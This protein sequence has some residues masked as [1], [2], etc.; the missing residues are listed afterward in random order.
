LS[1]P[2][3][4]RESR[5]RQRLRRLGL[6]ILVIMA[7]ASC[8]TGQQSGGEQGES[9]NPSPSPPKTTPSTKA[10]APQNLEVALGE[11]AELSDRTLTVNDFQGNFI[12]PGEFQPNPQ[13]GN[14]FFAVN[15]SVSN[16][17]NAAISISSFDFKLQDS[18]GVQRPPELITELPDE[19]NVSDIAPGGTLTGNMVFQAPQG[20]P[21][22]KLA[23]NPMTFP[24]ETVT[25]DLGGT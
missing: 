20:D 9:E 12:P 16:T 8:S 7:I 6:L 22:L 11:T 2:S 15:V 5:R 24:Q 17:S 23:Y 4:K 3:R 18:N 21:D 13:P 10:P 14:G 1:D 25:V 19:I